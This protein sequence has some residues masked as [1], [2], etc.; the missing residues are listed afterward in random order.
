MSVTKITSYEQYQKVINGD[1]PAVIDFYATC[2]VWPLQNYSPIFHKFAETPEILDLVEFYEVD[3]DEQREI[4]FD[5]GIRAMPT[6]ISFE[7]G[8]P[9]GTIR[10]ANPP[11]L[12][13]CPLYD[14][15]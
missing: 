14:S 6:F 12:A 7:N 2:T 13:V 11:A 5:A 8:K 10:G 1:K 9:S 4:S 15:L 3:V